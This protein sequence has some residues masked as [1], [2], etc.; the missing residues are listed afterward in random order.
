MGRGGGDFIA[1]IERLIAIYFNVCLDWTKWTLLIHTRLSPSFS[2]F[3][4]IS[5]LYLSPLHPPYPTPHGEVIAQHRASCRRL[6]RRQA[7]A[8]F[9]LLQLTNVY[10][11]ANKPSQTYQCRG[12]S[13]ETL[14]KAFWNRVL[15][16]QGNVMAEQSVSI[17]LCWAINGLILVQLLAFVKD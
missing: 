2:Y 4:R 9:W 15:Q 12:C 6:Q 5:F 1:P 14:R 16:E 10:F 3:P 13:T 7:F 17:W 8:W 11:H